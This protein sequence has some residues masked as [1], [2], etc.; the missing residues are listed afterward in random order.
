MHNDNVFLGVHIDKD[1][2]PFFGSLGETVKP[3]CTCEDI[4][5]L[6]RYIDELVKAASIDD[7]YAIFSRKDEASVEE[8]YAYAIHCSGG[9]TGKNDGSMAHTDY[10]KRLYIGFD[11]NQ[12]NAEMRWMYGRVMDQLDTRELAKYLR[13]YASSSLYF[14]GLDDRYLERMR[15]RRRRM[16]TPWMR[17]LI[18]SYTVGPSGPLEVDVI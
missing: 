17:T 7:S 13:R 11:R 5:T 16:L 3:P 10:W 9:Y 14:V 18:A 4:A 12:L 8:T 6:R 15:G 2:M 1:M